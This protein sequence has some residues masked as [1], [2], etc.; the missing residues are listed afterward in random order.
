MFISVQLVP[1]SLLTE[2][3]AH[4]MLLPQ[5][6]LGMPTPTPCHDLQELPVLF[7]EQDFARTLLFTLH[8]Y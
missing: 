2:T 4:K 8:M 6:L 7:A 1:N 3:L 5:E